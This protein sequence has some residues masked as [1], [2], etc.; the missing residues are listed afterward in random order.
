MH[1][2]IITY[3]CRSCDN[4]DKSW[5]VG[6]L[7]RAT[8]VITIIL[9]GQ[10]ITV[11]IRKLWLLTS[12]SMLAPLSSNSLMISQCPWWHATWRAVWPPS[13]S[14]ICAER[15]TQT[16]DHGKF[17]KTPPI[18]NLILNHKLILQW[19]VLNLILL[20]ITVYQNLGYTVLFLC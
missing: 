9:T 18:S 8:P 10:K 7:P 17:S 15:K 3:A 12:T 11:M 19:C 20:D 6:F 2:K 13:S 1:V 14:S 4:H 5:L 16:L